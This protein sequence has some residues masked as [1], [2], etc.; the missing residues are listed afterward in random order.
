MG[1]FDDGLYI[2][3]KKIKKKINSSKFGTSILL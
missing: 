3:Q 2:L 1:K